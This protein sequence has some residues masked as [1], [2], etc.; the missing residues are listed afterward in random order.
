MLCTVLFYT[1]IYCA[2]IEVYAQVYSAHGL[3]LYTGL[4]CTQVYLVSAQVYPEMTEERKKK[5]GGVSESRPPPRP[6]PVR[7]LVEDEKIGHENAE[8]LAKVR[9]NS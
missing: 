2:R 8:R 9:F 4:S 1:H 6:I 5:Q 7:S 3:I